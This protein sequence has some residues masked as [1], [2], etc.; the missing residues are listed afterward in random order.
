LG[1]PAKRAVSFGS[2]ARGE[3]NELSDIDLLVIASE[4]DGPRDIALVKAL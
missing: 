2:F 4:F 1:I 3:G